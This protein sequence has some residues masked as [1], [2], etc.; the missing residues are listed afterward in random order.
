MGE[1]LV[2]GLLLLPI[3]KTPKAVKHDIGTLFGDK[4]RKRDLNRLFK[5]GRSGNVNNDLIFQDGV[6]YD[7]NETRIT[8]F[9][10]AVNESAERNEGHLRYEDTAP[11]ETFEE[12]IQN[13]TGERENAR[14]SKQA[15]YQTIEAIAS[16]VKFLWNGTKGA[17]GIKQELYPTDNGSERKSYKT[18]LSKDGITP[19]RF[20]ETL[21][22]E[23][24]YKNEVLQALSDCNSQKKASELLDRLYTN[25]V[26]E[27]LNGRYQ[28]ETNDFD[29]FP[30]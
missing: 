23:E 16:G 4:I 25:H 20:A 2:F 17:R 24:D 6:T 5:S 1:F 9:K 28:H 21:S 14:T 19:E 15:Y 26:E 11:V 22:N 18:I 7:I 27:E 3:F 8:D 13:L 10:T 30:F 12:Y 29:N